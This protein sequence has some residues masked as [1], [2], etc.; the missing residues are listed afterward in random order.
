MLGPPAWVKDKTEESP[1]GTDEN[2]VTPRWG[3]TNKIYQGV[4][5]NEFCIFKRESDVIFDAEVDFEISFSW[6]LSNF[7][8]SEISRNPNFVC[9]SKTMLFTMF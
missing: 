8:A 3:L 6:L 5:G 1:K 4:F 7:D 9:S 2:G